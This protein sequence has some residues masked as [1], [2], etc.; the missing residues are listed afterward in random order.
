MNKS[1]IK[2]NIS[3]PFQ[4]LPLLPTP[5]PI[6]LA[7]S[8]LAVAG[9]LG[10]SLP[11]LAVDDIPTTRYQNAYR[12]CAGRLVQAGVSGE[13]AAS[14]CAGTL[15]PPDLA[16]CVVRIEERTEIAAADALATCRLVRR[17]VELA[18]CVVGISGTSEGQPVPGLL[19]YCGRSL[20]PARFAECVVG[21][22]GEVEIAPAQAMETCISASDRP[23]AFDPT[24]IPQGQ[25]QQQP[26][27]TSPSAPSV[28]PMLTPPIESTPAPTA[29]VNP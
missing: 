16:R 8:L 9:S 3:T 6:R 19:D 7:A 12:N 13:A 29:P 2:N 10:L 15:F 21:L 24:F 27:Q 26:V 4:A 14:A 18:R 23:I 1:K 20:L 28:P 11:S 22:R 5:Y 25:L 17:P